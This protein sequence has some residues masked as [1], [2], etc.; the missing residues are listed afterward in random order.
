LIVQDPTIGIKLLNFVLVVKELMSMILLKKNVYARNHYLMILEFNAL[1]VFLP[2][3]GIK[4][5]ILVNNV[6]HKLIIRLA[7][8]DVLLVL[9][10]RQS[11]MEENVWDVQKVQF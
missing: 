7:K 5:I 6:F 4:S 8:T 10:P 2:S 1:R 9:L 3:I 11:G